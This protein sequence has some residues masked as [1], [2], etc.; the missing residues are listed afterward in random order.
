MEVNEMNN[1]FFRG[2]YGWDQLSIY[3][4]IV[5]AI[6]LINKFTFIFG[7]IIIIYAVWRMFSK[8]T[9]KRQQE[10][11]AFQ[12]VNYKFNQS[13]QGFVRK[14][15]DFT[16]YKVFKCPNCSQKLRV[17]RGKGNITIRCKKCGNEFKGKS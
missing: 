8:N 9:F 2:G 11:L 17:P 6:L 3:L 14:I 13:I 4:A 10:L 1:N 7:V 12:R 15:K 5:G 16:H